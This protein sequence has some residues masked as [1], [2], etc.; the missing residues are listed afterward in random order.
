MMVKFLRGI[1]PCEV[2]GTLFLFLKNMKT[3]LEILLGHSFYIYLGPV[4]CSTLPLLSRLGL[5]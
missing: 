5:G 4:I 2:E 1:F 3:F